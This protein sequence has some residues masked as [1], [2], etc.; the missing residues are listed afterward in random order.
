MAAK[1]SQLRQKE[2]LE[3]KFKMEVEERQK[4]IAALVR[5]GWTVRTLAYP[6]TPR[7]TSAVQSN[8]AGR[9]YWIAKMPGAHE[10]VVRTI[11]QLKRY[12]LPAT[13]VS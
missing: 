11:D 6:E 12:A 10:V 9:V 7:H 5:L 4:A 2:L 8:H 1:F 13:Q 3:M